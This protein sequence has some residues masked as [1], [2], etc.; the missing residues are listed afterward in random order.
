MQTYYTTLRR[1]Q[2]TGLGFMCTVA[3][4]FTSCEDVSVEDP[5]SQQIDP[6]TPPTAIEQSGATDTE[7]ELNAR[8]AGKVFV[9][10]DEAGARTSGATTYINFQDEQACTW[11][12]NICENTFVTWPGYIQSTGYSEWGYAWMSDGPGTSF[13]SYGTGDHYHIMGLA[14]PEVEANPAHT[15]MFGSDWFVFYM[16]RN[17]SGRINFDLTQIKV[18]G[19]VPI[20]LWFKTASGSWRFWRSLGPGRWGLPGATNIQE[21]HVRAAS[22]A[23]GDNYS[24]DDIQVRGL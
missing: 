24:I 10:P 13:I 17:R 21:F 19:D 6:N 9:V 3:L 12:P 16:Q 20:T 18:N 4:L 7:G 23:S 8:P 14:M 11:N 2:R 1:I 15:A 22:G 5:S